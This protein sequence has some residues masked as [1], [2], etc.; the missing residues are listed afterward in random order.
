MNKYRVEVV[1]DR[2]CE[3]GEGPHWDV[4]SQTLYYVDLTAG[5]VCQL[6]VESKKSKAIH[7]GDNVSLVIPTDDNQL[8]ITKN[9]KLFKFDSASN[10]K[11]L[12]AEVEQD[13]K[14]NR[15][16]DGK[17]DASGRLWLGTMAA[18]SAPGVVAPN[19]GKAQ[20]TRPSLVSHAVL[21]GHLLL[22]P[23]CTL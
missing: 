11:Q 7:I 22:I 4:G 13:L 8:I 19:L 5:D 6:E 15:F 17:C 3:L 9:N 21:G 14:G 12:L 10:R 16:N 23:R 1:S 18:E 20:V 2:R